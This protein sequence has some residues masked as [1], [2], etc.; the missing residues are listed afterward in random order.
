MI[1]YKNKY[2][3]YK[4]KYLNYK[5]H[6]GGALSDQIG[7]A[8]IFRH[9]L[10]DILKPISEQVKT[11]KADNPGVAFP[12]PSEMYARYEVLQDY[13][14]HLSAIV[15]CNESILH[16]RRGDTRSGKP[17]PYFKSNLYDLDLGIQ[18][19]L[20]EIQQFLVPQIPDQHPNFVIFQSLVGRI[21]VLNP[22]PFDSVTIVCRGEKR[23]GYVKSFQV[24]PSE[25]RSVSPPAPAPVYKR[26]ETQEHVSLF[27]LLGVMAKALTPTGAISPKVF[28]SPKAF[29]PMSCELNEGETPR[30][31][32]SSIQ[33]QIEILQQHMSELQGCLS[34]LQSQQ[35][36]KIKELE[37]VI[38]Q[39]ESKIQQ[40]NEKHTKNIQ[41]IL[42]TRS[43]INSM[44][45]FPSLEVKTVSKESLMRK[46]ISINSEQ[47]QIQKET[48]IIRTR[49]EM[50]QGEIIKL[51]F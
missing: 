13:I 44:P 50:L 28:I 21:N 51:N 48:Q 6:K 31:K 29:E 43:A 19:K 49:I 46:I 3:K 9:I 14:S 16:N 8:V 12:V 26:G 30:M 36:N 10:I 27:P 33:L 39:N 20:N 4:N 22:S 40:L 42:E 2:L 45:E 7:I 18:C 41:I 38:E 5:L 23:L 1:N 11:I 15:H 25:S 17:N 24:T 34:K 47:K 32:M 37:S 35:Q